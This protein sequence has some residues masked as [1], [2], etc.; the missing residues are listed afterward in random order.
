VK[1]YWCGEPI[2]SAAARLRENCLR[3]NGSLF[4]PGVE[5]WTKANL[6]IVEQRI[7]IARMSRTV[8][9]FGDGPGGLITRRRR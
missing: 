7:G 1:A 6:S 2:Y 3:A 9:N 8:W 5:I 4:T